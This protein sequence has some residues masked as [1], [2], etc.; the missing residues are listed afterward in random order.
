MAGNLD[1]GRS[2][3]A[4]DFVKLAAA[5]VPL[6]SGPKA[7]SKVRLEKMPGAYVES[8]SRTDVFLT[9]LALDR[10]SIAGPAGPQ[11]VI[12]QEALWQRWETES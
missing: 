9:D 8:A 2:L 12:K 5:M 6:L 11:E 10:L 7:C 3:A 1:R 4:A